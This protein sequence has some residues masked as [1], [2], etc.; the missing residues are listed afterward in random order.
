MNSKI[1]KFL[2]LFLISISLLGYAE[3][4]NKKDSKGLN[5][6]QGN[7][8]RTFLNINNISTQIYNDG[9]SDI[10]PD[11]NSG[12]IFPKGS[13]KTA[14]FESGLL[15]GVQ[16]PGDPQVRVGGSAYRQGLQSGKILSPGVAEDPALAKNRIYRVRPDIYPG[17]PAVDL[18]G[19][20]TDEG[21]Y[22]NLRSE[23]NTK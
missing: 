21:T 14:V 20:A 9:N 1:S 16:I 22:L 4:G 5:K 11:G 23:H 19:A 10:T 2:F 6:T 17:G 3:D 15:W 12:V 8:V 18:S 7:P 13:G